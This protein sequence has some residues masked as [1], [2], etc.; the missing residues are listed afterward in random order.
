MSSWGTVYFHPFQE[1][2]PV[3][4]GL[5]KMFYAGFSRFF[6]NSL[7]LQQNLI[8]GNLVYVFSN[9]PSPQIIPDKEN[10]IQ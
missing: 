8:A 3:H 4:S 2:S 5:T 1:I 6:P 7:I 10:K 9:S